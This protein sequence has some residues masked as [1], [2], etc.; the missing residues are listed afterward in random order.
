MTNWWEVSA[1]WA[2]AAGSLAAVAVA[3]YIAVRGWRDAERREIQ[4]QAR[5]VHC[6]AKWEIMDLPNLSYAEG[7]AFVVRNDSDQPIYRVRILRREQEYPMINAHD[8]RVETMTGDEPKSYG[9]DVGKSTD[10]GPYP[11]SVVF[12]DAAAVRWLR[13]DGLQKAPRGL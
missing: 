4:A 10:A 11:V 9:F 7:P 12:S 6:Y 2:G 1:G 13:R 8:S 3:L 5:L